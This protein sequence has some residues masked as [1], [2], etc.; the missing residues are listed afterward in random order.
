MTDRLWRNVVCQ[1]NLWRNYCDET[2]SVTIPLWRKLWRKI[3]NCDGRCDGNCD[4]KVHHNF[5]RRDSSPKEI[6]WRKGKILTDSVTNSD[7][8]AT[9]H[10]KLWRKSVTIFRHN[11][12]LK[13][14]IVT[15]FLHNL[16]LWRN[17][18]TNSVTIFLK[19][20]KKVLKP[21]RHFGL[22]RMWT[23]KTVINKPQ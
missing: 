19:G 23:S 3:D 12:E 9:I 11:S 2:I 4:V 21:F 1:N 22:R 8:I 6:L 17:S 14:K 20:P 16:V 10:H 13:R 15:D 5:G 18:V 7:G